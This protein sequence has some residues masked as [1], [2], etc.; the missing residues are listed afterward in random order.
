M[1]T[2]G[3]ATRRP[4]EVVGAFAHTLDSM[5]NDYARMIRIAAKLSACL[6]GCFEEYRDLIPPPTRQSLPFN[7]GNNKQPAPQ[8]QLAEDLLSL[9]RSMEQRQRCP[10]APKVPPTTPP[11]N[12]RFSGNGNGHQDY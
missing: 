12:G 9:V 1:A 11:N 2:P 10:E 5:H 4:H 6:D 7:A 3:R 8:E